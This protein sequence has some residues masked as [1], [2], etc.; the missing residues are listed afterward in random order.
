MPEKQFLIQ[1]KETEIQ[2]IVESLRDTTCNLIE[3]PMTD[4]NI[5]NINYFLNLI[6]KIGEE[7]KEVE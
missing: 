6:K 3:C 7:K 1:L 5:Q 2:T 4:E